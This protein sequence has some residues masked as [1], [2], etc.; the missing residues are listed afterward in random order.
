MGNLYW[1]NQCG[2]HSHVPTY[3]SA[4]F[5]EETSLHT[6]LRDTQAADRNM[7][8]ISGSRL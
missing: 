5:P 2:M 4:T 1:S 3:G 7:R 8:D 6:S